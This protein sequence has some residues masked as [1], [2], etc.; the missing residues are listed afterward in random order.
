MKIQIF[1]APDE[2]RDFFSMTNWQNSCFF[3][4]MIDEMHDFFATDWQN[5]QFSSPTCIIDDIVV[6]FS[7]ANNEISRFFSELDWWNLQLL[8]VTD[9]RNLWLFPMNDWKIRFFFFSFSHNLVRKFTFFLIIIIPKYW[10]FRMLQKI[11]DSWNS[12]IYIFL[13]IANYDNS[14]KNYIAD[15]GTLAACGKI[16]NR[17]SIRLFCFFQVQISV[18]PTL[19]LY[20]RTYFILHFQRNSVISGDVRINGKYMRKIPFFCQNHFLYISKCCITAK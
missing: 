6:F 20:F 16:I 15:W 3:P 4:Q 13:K 18:F 17:N 9:W 10:V 5:V 12:A 1:S 8:S 11:N 7:W 14:Q 2:I 19:L